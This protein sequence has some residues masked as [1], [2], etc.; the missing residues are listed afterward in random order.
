MILC[1]T[2]ASN[3]NHHT[4]NIRIKKS[5]VSS[6]EPT[7]ICE[8]GENQSKRVTSFT[9]ADVLTIEQIRTFTNKGL[10]S[11]V[12]VKEGKINMNISR[13]EKGRFYSLRYGGKKYLINKPRKGIIDVYRVVE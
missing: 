11:P 13:M 12:S 7:Y 8:G 2:H 10:D 1:N 9:G 5:S 3:L 6:L 4:I